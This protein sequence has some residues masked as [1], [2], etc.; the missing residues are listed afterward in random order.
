MEDAKSGS[1]EPILSCGAFRSSKE[2]GADGKMGPQAVEFAF[3]AVIATILVE[4]MSPNDNAQS[5]EDGS[6]K[7][8]KISSSKV[9]GNLQIIN[10]NLISAENILH[11]ASLI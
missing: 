8:R 4:A 1:V 5:I 2:A 6:R 11:Q 10:V 7:R 3:F 9:S